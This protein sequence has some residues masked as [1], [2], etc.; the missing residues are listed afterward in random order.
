MLIKALFRSRTVPALF[1]RRMGTEKSTRLGG[2]S[3]G[4]LHS[5]GTLLLS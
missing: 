1:L 4:E 3:G 5:L 2:P